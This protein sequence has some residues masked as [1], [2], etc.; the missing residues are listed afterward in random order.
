MPKNVRPV[1]SILPRAISGAANCSLTIAEARLESLI[2]DLLD[3]LERR[4]ESL[5][6]FRVDR[7]CI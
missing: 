4:S 7:K 6:T 1:C 5:E 2:A 3:L